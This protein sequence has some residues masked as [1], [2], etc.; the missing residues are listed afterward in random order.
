MNRPQSHSPACLPAGRQDR[1]IRFLC[2]SGF[3]P[4]WEGQTDDTVKV[5]KKLP[6]KRNSINNFLV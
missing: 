4:A 3:P 5:F 6:I 1:G 2:F